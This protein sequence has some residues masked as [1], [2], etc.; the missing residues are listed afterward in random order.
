MQYTEA[1]TQ[2]LQNFWP[3][4]RFLRLNKAEAK[5][6]ASG[7]GTVEEDGALAEAQTGP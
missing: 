4:K 7:E 1:E 5:E 2:V 6:E 3:S